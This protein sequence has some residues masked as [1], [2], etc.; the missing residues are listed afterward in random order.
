[1]LF[2]CLSTGSIEGL[3]LVLSQADCLKQSRLAREFTLSFFRLCSADVHMHCF[4]VK[5][6]GQI[7]FLVAGCCLFVLQ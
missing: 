2:A 3:Q 4:L 5:C 1:M 6:L 7:A